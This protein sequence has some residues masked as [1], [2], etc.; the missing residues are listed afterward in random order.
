MWRAIGD[1]SNAAVASRTAFH[2]CSES[3]S[4][5]GSAF[6]VLKAVRCAQML[7]PARSVRREE[8]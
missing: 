3:T 6:R 8:F 4:A 7:R 5:E 1:A 2:A